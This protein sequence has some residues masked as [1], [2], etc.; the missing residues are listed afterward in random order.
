MCGEGMF[1][2]HRDAFAVSDRAALPGPVSMFRG[3]TFTFLMEVLWVA[4]KT[5]FFFCDAHV[6]N[7]SCG[8]RGCKRRP[9]PRARGKNTK[10]FW[11]FLKTCGNQAH[12]FWCV[13]S[14]RGN[15]RLFP[16]CVLTVPRRPDRDQCVRR[17]AFRFDITAPRS[18]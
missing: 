1:H 5:V 7:G 4:Q 3:S 2:C 13:L 17:P 16:V 14:D 12:V 15:R 18:M 9:M 10:K 6:W 11:S 8:K